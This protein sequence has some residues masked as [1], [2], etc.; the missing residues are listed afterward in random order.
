MAHLNQIAMSVTDLRRTHAWYREVFGFIPAGG[1]SAFK[2]YLA[3]KVQGVKGVA[4]TCWWL[5]D[6]QD[7]FQ[8]E[9]FEFE[10]PAV[11]PLPADWRLCDIGYG[12]VGM[13]V[14]D[15]DTVLQRVSEQGSEL[16]SDP[17]GEAGARRVCVRDPE[18]V[19]LEIMED[20]VLAATAGAPV[21]DAVAVVTRSITV[22]VADLDKSRS[23]FVDMLELEEVHDLCLHTEAH[24]A[25]WGLPGA[26]RQTLLLRAGDVLVELVEYSDP[27]GRK[28]AQDYRISDQGLLNIALG[29]RSR[30]EFERIYQ[31]CLQGGV[32]GNWRP[33]RLGAWSVVYVNDEQGFSVELLHVQKWYD[34]H[35]GFKPKPAPVYKRSKNMKGWKT[36][37]ITGGGSGIGLRLAEMLVREGTSVGIIDR[38]DS[39]QAREILEA[40]ARQQ[41]AT[42]VEFFQADVTDAAALERAVNA[43]AEGLGVPDVAINCAGIQVA[44]PF[45]ELT[46]EEFERVININLCGSRNFAAAVLPRM[47]S[48]A[49]LALMASLAGLV[50]SHS[51]AAYNAS[52]FGVIGLAGALRLEYIAKGIEVSVICP[53]EVD[54]PMVAEERKT[55]PA[56]AVK[57]KETAG[58]MELQPACDEIMKQLR[59][60]RVT[61][62]PSFRA[63]AVVWVAR[64][65]PGL[66]RKLSERI[67]LAT[68]E[69]T[70]RSSA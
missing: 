65:F 29:F 9:L 47:Q 41:V 46:A 2:G 19:L 30:K 67:V 35:M 45:A 32:S 26:Q 14:G 60:R 56:V 21:R 44:K 28:Q 33:L 11:R 38:S 22:S 12:M 6:Q 54:T 57:L 40:L 50:P 24:E 36:A 68:A 16:M 39:A 37:V 52:K 53:P 17:M 58:T 1:T 59:A 27:L 62:I 8:L 43:A 4:S 64:V 23:F 18:G 3:E 61:I 55:L 63:R 51:Y 15:F 42:Q 10:R 70:G 31:R 25:L 48:G 34:R 49:Q 20:D 5:L 7:Y 69:E 66:M 13:H